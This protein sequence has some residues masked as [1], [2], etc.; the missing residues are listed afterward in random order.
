MNFQE[1]FLIFV[2]FFEALALSKIDSNRCGSR[3]TV[4]GTIYG[5]D[6]ANRNS[7]PWL[8]ALFDRKNERFFCAGSLISEKHILSGK[9]KSF[10]S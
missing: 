9:N 1:S 6:R 2:A 4:V 8:V 10:L 5:G 3:H 7:W